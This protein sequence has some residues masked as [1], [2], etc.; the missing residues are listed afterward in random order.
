M[1][2][3]RTSLLVAAIWLVG[4]G[5]ANAPETNRNTGYTPTLKQDF[6]VE[7]RA[8]WR[9]I[10]QWS[11]LCEEDFGIGAEAGLG[12]LALF[13][14]A[15]AESILRVTCGV[16]AYQT[17]M[18]FY[19]ISSVNGKPTAT[20]LQVPTY[21]LVQKKV[22]SRV[23]EYDDDINGSVLGFDTFNENQKTVTIFTKD[24]GVGD[25]GTRETF[26]V[27]S[28]FTLLETQYMSCAAADEF[29]LQNPD[30][31]EM[32]AWPVVYEAK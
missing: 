9:E 2:I 30:A 14:Y 6:T 23:Y 19:H 5:C 26:R 11:D 17:S 4:A 8:E 18:L 29:H 20:L 28:E 22:V 32:P 13:S 3:L 16:Y 10:A 15:P 7:E 12:G 31:E 25:C 1:N 27:G 24:R 21:D